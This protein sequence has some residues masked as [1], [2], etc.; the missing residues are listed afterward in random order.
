MPFYGEVVPYSVTPVVVIVFIVTV[1]IAV[2]AEVNSDCIKY[3]LV[4]LWQEVGHI[5]IFPRIREGVRVRDNV[6]DT[7]IAPVPIAVHYDLYYKGTLIIR[8]I[9]SVAVLI[10]YTVTDK[11]KVLIRQGICFDTVSSTVRGRMNFSFHSQNST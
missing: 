4:Y 11:Y 8:N 6:I 10:G 5:S 7:V 9:I 3:V 1:R 2:I